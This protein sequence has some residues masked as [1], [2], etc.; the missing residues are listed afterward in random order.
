LTSL[1]ATVGT[2]SAGNYRW[3][4]ARF[5]ENERRISRRA[6]LWLHG[7]RTWAWRTS[8]FDYYHRSDGRNPRR[9]LPMV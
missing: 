8:N 2:F 6:S 4:A 9:V 5:I 1:A 3:H 7:W